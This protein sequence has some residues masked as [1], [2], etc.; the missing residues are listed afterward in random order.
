MAFLIAAIMSRPYDSGSEGCL[1]NEE[2]QNGRY[3]RNALTQLSKLVDSRSQ[4]RF[5]C[6]WYGGHKIH[7]KTMKLNCLPPS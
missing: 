4:T 1:S 7:S 2:Y 6:V 3:S 5:V